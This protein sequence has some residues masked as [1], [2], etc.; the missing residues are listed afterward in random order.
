MDKR[1][2]AAVVTGLVLVGGLSAGAAW[3]QSSGSTPAT[4]QT[5]S[6]GT[7][8]TQ[9]GDQT[10]PDAAGKA[11]PNE[12]AESKEGVEQET[13]G[14]EEP[15][16]ATPSA[17]SSVAADRFP[18]ADRPGHCSWWPPARPARPSCVA[19]PARWRVLL[20][21]L[22]DLAT[23]PLHRAERGTGEQPG[24]HSAQQHQRDP[25]GD[26]ALADLFLGLLGRAERAADHHH[27][28]TARSWF[29]QAWA[30]RTSMLPSRTR[31]R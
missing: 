14:A 19:R 3:G 7:D 27:L 1:K 26:Q 18:R 8:S 21:D 2:L 6:P 4:S 29:G 10:T 20:G 13:K 28:M 24:A 15:G 11:E 22:V 30:S 31:V 5:T 23:Q 25:A 12:Q 16:D 9:Q 17:I